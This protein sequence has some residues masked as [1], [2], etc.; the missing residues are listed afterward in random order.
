MS[1]DARA[2]YESDCLEDPVWSRLVESMC[3]F[4]EKFGCPTCN[5]KG[6]TVHEQ[7]SPY[8]PVAWSHTCSACKGT[9]FRSK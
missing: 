3:R 7:M 6:R 5:G 1:A 2:R 4:L 8:G 9:G